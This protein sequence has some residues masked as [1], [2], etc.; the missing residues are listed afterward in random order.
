MA[1]LQEP[2]V[3]LAQRLA[4]NEKAIRSKAIKKLRKYIVVRSQNA[5]GGFKPDE[6]LK[7]WKGL[8]YCLWMQDK[9]LLQEEL[10]NQISTLIH[11]F[12]HTDQQLL[13]ME[14]FLQTLKREWTGIDR[15]RMDKFYQVVRF[16]FRQSFEVLRRQSW[17]S[18][19]VARFLQL[20]TSHLLQ[21]DSGAPSGLQLHI[22]NLYLSELAAV[23]AAELTADQNLMFIEPFCK[24]A[25]KTKNRMLLSAICSSIFSTIIDQAPFAVEDLMKEVNS[26]DSGQASEEE[27]GCEEDKTSSK[28]VCRRRS[29]RQI[30]GNKPNNDEEEEDDLSHLEDSDSES[31]HEDVGPVLQF[32]FAAVAQKLF[33]LASRSNTPGHNRKKLYKIIKVLRDLSEGVFPQDEYPEEVSTDEDDDMFGSRKRM[34]RSAHRETEEEASVTKKRKEMEEFGKPNNADS[35]DEAVSNAKEKKQKKKKQKKKKKKAENEENKGILECT[36]EPATEAHLQSSSPS[37]ESPSEPQPPAR[38]TEPSISSGKKM[39][40]NVCVSGGSEGLQE[41]QSFTAAEAPVL[42]KKKK[43]K[44]LPAEADEQ[45]TPPDAAAPSPAKSKQKGR[46]VKSFEQLVGADSV[47]EDVKPAVCPESP[48]VV[49]RTS[50]KKSRR[51]KSPAGEQ[52]VPVGADG[53]EAGASEADGAPTPQK[54]KK[55]KRSA[56]AGEKAETDPEKKKGPKLNWSP[57][58]MDTEPDVVTPARTTPTKKRKKIPVEFEFEADELDVTAPV[59][60]ITGAGVNSTEDV[61]TP[62]T[63]LRQKKLQKKTVGA[64]GSDFITF[65]SKARVPKLLF[66]KS[67]RRPNTPLPSKKK[68]QTPKS[69]PKKVTFGLRN[70]KTAEFRKTDRSLLLSPEGS[71]RVPFDPKQKPK[72]GVLKSQTPPGTRSL[73]ETPDGSKKTPR[74]AAK[75]RPLAADFF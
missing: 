11:H 14:S 26:S 23:G 21:A 72:C 1:S 4:S 2:E 70:N 60:D 5:S 65:S 67:S 9:L 64:S 32:D 55:R 52:E 43:K 58:H 3:L 66:C 45:I 17:E 16:M 71:S 63:P 13:Y 27:D 68:K 10:S 46:K 33:E 30:D 47:S 51:K 53:G 12:H 54:K 44:S 7:L 74:G 20:L 49:E 15:L 39:K 69:E 34:K 38:V 42:V 37:S 19:V 73:R 18:S 40:G 75:G 35:V 24:T 31:A 6:L 61:C 62:A 56:A 57:L 22:L 36:Q 29:G 50:A 25:A 48:A 41:Q 59:G 8:F 28:A